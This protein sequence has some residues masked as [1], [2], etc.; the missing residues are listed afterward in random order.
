MNTGDQLSEWKEK[1]N[2]L[3]KR[4]I[5]LLIILIWFST[6]SSCVHF[7]S[8]SKA[9]V[10][11]KQE[12]ITN[13]TLNYQNIELLTQFDNSQIF[14]GIQFYKDRCFVDICEEE[15]S[16]YGK[17]CEIDLENGSIKASTDRLYRQSLKSIQFNYL[18]TISRYAY[19]F[20]SIDTLSPVGGIDR[21]EYELLLLQDLYSICASRFQYNSPWNTSFFRSIVC[22]DNHFK[23]KWEF[24]PT[25][26]KSEENT[27]FAYPEVIVINHIVHCFF[28]QQGKIYHYGIDLETGKEMVNELLFT[29]PYQIT[30]ANNNEKTYLPLNRSSFLLHSS[31]EAILTN[32]TGVAIAYKENTNLTFQCWRWNSDKLSYQKKFSASI[33]NKPDVEYIIHSFRPEINEDVAI[34]EMESETIEQIYCIDLLD[35][36]IIRNHSIVETNT[37]QLVRIHFDEEKNQES[38]STKFLL[39]IVDTPLSKNIKPSKNTLIM[40][41]MKTA[42]KNWEITCENYSGV[43]LFHRPYIWI[44]KEDDDENQIGFEI[45][46]IEGACI[47]IIDVKEDLQ[48]SWLDFQQKKKRGNFNWLTNYSVVCSVYN[49][50]KVY[51]I[52]SN[53]YV[54]RWSMHD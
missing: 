49:S 15:D 13:P 8:F 6:M 44:V 2:Q 1:M 37:E 30:F 25:L 5:F 34:I 24:I 20:Y 45:Y 36:K 27:Y 10:S 40:F 48:E 9:D 41:D 43:H 54:Y 31:D 52:T 33:S 28:N 17:I 42:E 21:L 11:K 51:F 4:L 35:M 38:N 26:L 18:H 23:Q 19:H 53:G 29:S 50:N 7:R 14:G 3:I 16:D 46:D 32:S 22:M 12:R 47:G 39:E